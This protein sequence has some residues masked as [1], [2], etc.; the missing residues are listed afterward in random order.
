MK[1]AGDYILH[2]QIGF[3]GAYFMYS[4]DK[5]A[6]LYPA[7]AVEGSA[8]NDPASS[9]EIAEVDYLPWLNT[10]FSLQYVM[11]NKFNGGSSNYDGSGRN[12]SD[13]NALFVSGWIAF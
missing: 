8:T 2:N 6:N 9:G 7:G 3:S 10:K 5:D 11:Y 12:A 13:N 1:L 4:G